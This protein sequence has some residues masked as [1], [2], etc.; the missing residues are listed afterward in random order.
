MAIART[1]YTSSIPSNVTTSTRTDSF[2]VDVTAD[3]L[4]CGVNTQD[5]GG[6]F[7]SATY[8][9]VSMTQTSAG[10]LVQAGG[11]GRSLRNTIYYLVAPSTGTNNGVITMSEPISNGFRANYAAYSGVDQSTPEEDAQKGSTNSGLK[12]TLTLTASVADCWLFG[13]AENES[14]TFNIQTTWAMLYASSNTFGDSN[15]ALSSGSITAEAGFNDGTA[16]ILFSAI[17][18]KPAASGGSYRFVP[19]LTPFAGL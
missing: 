14:G 15:G 18:I 1:N 19:Q 11:A 10:T 8:N 3:F 17:L 5:A 16:R 12:V 7:V 13:V 9:G 2:T 6:T 4:A